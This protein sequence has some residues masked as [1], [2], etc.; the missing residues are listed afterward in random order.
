MLTMS[1]FENSI[2]LEGASSPLHL[3]ALPQINHPH[4]SLKSCKP[5]LQQLEKAL[6]QG[7]P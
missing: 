3:S 4:P 1:S 6:L 2:T 7:A 5:L